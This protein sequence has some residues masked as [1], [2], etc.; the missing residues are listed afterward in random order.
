MNGLTVAAIIPTFRRWDHLLST[1]RQLM[2]QTRAPDEIIVVDQ[3]PAD[4][5]EPAQLAQL[6]QLQAQH[7]RLVYRCQAAPHVYRARNCAAN[8]ATA[9]LLLYLD[10]DVILDPRL[11][12]H[13]VA[14]LVDPAVDAVTGRVI[15]RGIDRRHLPPPP[16][17]TTAT[18]RAFR[19]GAYR[20]DVRI[21]RVSYCVAGHF[22]V[23]RA[24]LA[25]I[26]GWDE[27]VLTYGDKDMG[28]RLH[29]AGKNVVYDPRPV[30]THLA[31]PA[32]GTRLSDSRA[33][34][35]SWQQSPRISPESGR[36]CISCSNIYL[37]FAKLY[38][39]ATTLTQNFTIRLPGF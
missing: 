16:P 14:I 23:R 37:E 3:T 27:H 26:G 28:L 38:Y 10:D 32:G 7:A 19:F 34:W 13:H 18:D 17:D 29:A 35:S 31:A 4:E 39:T 11:V 22:C 30:L 5:I 36:M 21:E 25:E 20:D 24:V 8:L 12:E 6:K 1:L 33:P 15:T 9:D 2:A